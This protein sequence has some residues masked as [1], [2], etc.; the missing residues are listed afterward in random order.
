L[1]GSRPPIYRQTAD[2]I[3]AMLADGRLG[4][5]FTVPEAAKLTGV[6]DWAARKAAEHLAERGLI[7]PQQGTGYRA[8]VTPEEAAA[9]QVDDRPVREQ[10]AELQRDISDLRQRLGRMEASL[11]TLTG[12]PR[13]GKR[14][15]AK[16]AADGG[17]R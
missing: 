16:A 1:T 5:E 9:L 8:L 17:R 14:D 15:Q 2:E 4:L 11:A 6:K 3:L 12:K 10:I 13:G 7:E